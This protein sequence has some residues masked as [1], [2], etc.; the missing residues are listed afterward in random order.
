[1]FSPNSFRDKKDLLI[2]SNSS[3]TNQK[4]DKENTSHQSRRLSASSIP[5]KN[6]N[7]VSFRLRQEPKQIPKIPVVS[8]QS[9]D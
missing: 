7:N 3:L 6:E 1:L 5:V 9:D 4:L 8:T 2:T